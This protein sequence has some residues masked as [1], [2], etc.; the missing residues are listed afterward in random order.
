MQ[1]TAKSG[2]VDRFEQLSKEFKDRKLK[3]VLEVGEE[4]KFWQ[5][6]EFGTA[7]YRSETV[8]GAADAAEFGVTGPGE[9]Y[10]IHPHG[11]H[12]LR[13]PDFENKYNLP[14]DEE[15]F[16]LADAILHHPGI[17]AIAFIRT[18]LGLIMDNFS[19]TVKQHIEQ[20]GIALSSIRAAMLPSMEFAKK[21][22]V[23]SLAVGAPGTRSDGK[24]RGRTA[25]SVFDEAT[26]IRIDET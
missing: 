5:W 20:S 3:A 8:E 1:F 23:E 25:A 7:T 16:A 21:R 13:F 9:E 24:L 17:P 12:P 6:L 4:A 10:E 18:R 11:P 2:L 19:A 15:G 26:T 22:I 14:H